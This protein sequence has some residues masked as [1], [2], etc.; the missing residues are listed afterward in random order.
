MERK[1]SDVE[2]SN[3]Y[4]EMKNKLTILF[5]FFTVSVFSQNSTFRK[6]YGAFNAFNQANAVI[7]DAENNI[8]VAGGT[9]GYVAVGGDMWLMKTDSLGNVLWNKVYGGSAAD[10]AMSVCHTNDGGFFVCGHS[11]SFANGDYD[12]YLVKTDA[13]GVEIWSK[14]YGGDDWETA[15]RIIPL[16]DGNF[17]IIGTTYSYGA[18]NADVWLLKIDSEG[19]I[20]WDLT[21]GT[22]KDETGNGVCTIDDGNIMIVSTFETETDGL[23]IFFAKIDLAGNVLFESLFGGAGNQRGNDVSPRIDNGFSIGGSIEIIEGLE[24]FFPINFDA[25]ANFVYATFGLNGVFSPIMRLQHLG[26]DDHLLVIK[27][28]PFNAEIGGAWRSYFD[29]GYTCSFSLG[30]NS[31]YTTTDGCTDNSRHLILVGTH[32]DLNPGQTS[33]YILKADSFCIAEGEVQVGLNE[34][35]E[36]VHSVLFPNPTEN[37]C[38]IQTSSP[39]FD[40]EFKVLLADLQGRVFPVNFS[41]VNATTAQANFDRHQLSS[42]IYLLKIQNQNGILIRRVSLK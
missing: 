42:G 38:Y 40:K 27:E 26:N 13:N 22:E 31:P 19:E 2:I 6:T 34:T 28:K 23:D 20:I 11:N 21:F 16:N 39:F 25:E 14:T 10:I 36:Q 4:I 18:G 7:T 5:I 15:K 37:N 8:F 17:A 24:E 3:T 29:F 12:I 41:K 30:G 33:A 35:Q 1:W 32:S 9:S